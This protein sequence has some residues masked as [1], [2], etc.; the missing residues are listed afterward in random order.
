MKRNKILFDFMQQTF[1][2]LDGL[3]THEKCLLIDTIKEYQS[4]NHNAAEIEKPNRE[5]KARNK[6]KEG[7]SNTSPKRA[8][9]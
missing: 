1:N 5:T 8:V 9:L 7:K 6:R 2:C 4:R 3:Y